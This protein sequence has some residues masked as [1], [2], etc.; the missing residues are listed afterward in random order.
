MNKLMG[1][2]VPVRDALV[3]SSLAIGLLSGGVVGAPQDGD[4][5]GDVA[6]ERQ[7]QLERTRAELG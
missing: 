1:R 7:E 3:V 6:G 4:T 2:L 5:I